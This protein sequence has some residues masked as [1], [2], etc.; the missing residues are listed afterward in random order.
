MQPLSNILPLMRKVLADSLELLRRL[1]KS[2]LYLHS[3]V[4]LSHFGLIILCFLDLVIVRRDRVEEVSLFLC[5][6]PN[7]RCVGLG[8]CFWGDT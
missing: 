1:M 6:A 7:V 8:L 4:P 5:F 3:M 2:R